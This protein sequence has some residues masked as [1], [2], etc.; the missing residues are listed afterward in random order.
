MPIVSADWSIADATKNIRYIG[1]A[2]GGGSPSYATVIEF[3]RWLQD[4]A[5]DAVFVGDDALDITKTTPS[6]RSTD[7]IITLLGTYNIDDTAAEHLYDGSIIQ[8][9]GA[10]IYDGIVNYGNTTFLN[11]LQNGAIVTSQFWNSFAPAG[12][13]ADATQGISHRFL[14]KVRTGGADIDGR[15]L[16]G[17]SRQINKT[18]SEFPIAATARGNNVLALSEADDLNN[19]TAAATIAT[20]TDIVNDNQGYV[21]IDADGNAVN[22][23][24]YSNWEIGSRTKNQFYERTKWLT[25]QGNTTPIYG[26]PGQVFRGITH[27]ITIDTPTGTFVQPEAVSWAGGAGQLLAINSVTAGTKMWIQLLTGVT[28]TDN[29]VITGGTSAATCLV[30]VTVVSRPVSVPFVGA[31]TGSAIIGAYGLGIGADDLA[32]ADKVTDL[33]N[34]LRV[35]PNNV[36]FSV[37]GL[38]VGEDRVL[39]GPGSGGVLLENQFTLA[40]A[41]TTDNITTITVNTAIP[42]DTPSAGTIR[43]KD[44]AGLFRRLPYTSYAGS[45]FTISTTDGNEDFA[46][47]NASIGNSVFISYID[48]LATATSEAFTSVYLADRQLFIRVRDGASTPIKTFET[49]GT[50]GSGGGSTTVIRTTDQ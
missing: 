46:A 36:V 48:K 44:N 29:Q 34:T 28:P 2:H 50:L 15:K 13:N 26:L 19:A 14:I 35:P 31:S 49:T 1:A 41:R 24:Y 37:A 7:N 5:D 47:V 21:G 16:L 38:V 11:L 3:H 17:M 39:V 9:A 18:W 32:A 40:V 20:W 33:T 10:V 45:V 12:F 42:T 23:F 8:S 4:K 27:E 22:E 25:R 30:N 6:E 43:V